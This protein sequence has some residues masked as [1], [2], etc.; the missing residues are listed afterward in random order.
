MIGPLKIAAAKSVK[1]F[2]STVVNILPT[3]AFLTAA[4]VL[5]IGGWLEFEEQDMFC[6][7]SLLYAIYRKDWGTVDDILKVASKPALYKF[8]L[9]EDIVGLGPLQF[10]TFKCE[11]DITLLNKLIAA[12]EPNERL[13]I[14]KKIK[15]LDNPFVY[16]LSLK[17]KSHIDVVMNCL[18][19]KDRFEFLSQIDE[20]G[21]TP[22]M[23]QACFGEN[24]DM[25]K[26]FLRHCPNDKLL[27]HLNTVNKAGETVLTKFAASEANDSFE[28][29]LKSIPKNKREQF[30]AHQ[31]Q[32]KKAALISLA[33]KDENKIA[34]LEKYGLK[35]HDEWRKVTKEQ[36]EA[37]EQEWKAKE[38]FKQLFGSYPLQWLGIEGD[39]CEHSKIKKA[40]HS[41]MLL[42][43]PDRNPNNQHAA[44][45]SQKIISAYEFYDKPESRIKYTNF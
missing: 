27:D 18:P 15:H 25:V 42:F 22:V 31:S 8:L 45:M 39:E 34:T 23:S 3:K 9:A 24:K 2:K 14:F 44:D 1:W 4:R 43:H 40:Y 16:H 33:N 19:E 10:A 17:S 5:P 26:A 12:I 37:L 36:L 29:I 28:Y 13:N 11:E 21:N 20:L 41:K 35:I 38:K 6:E 30:F 7:S 32:G